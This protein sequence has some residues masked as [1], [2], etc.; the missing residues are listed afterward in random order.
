MVCRAFRSVWGLAGTVILAGCSDPEPVKPIPPAP[1]AWHVVLDETTLDRAVLSVWGSSP[2]N[3]FAVGGALGNGQESLVLHYDGKAWKELHPGGTETYWWVGGSG[4]ND[5]WMVG[6]N[7]RATHWDGSVFQEHA[8]GVMATLWG[9]WAASP[10]DVWFVGGTP[11]G[12]PAKPNDIVLH[13]DG[14]GF[15]NVTLP[16]ALGRSF[17]KVWGTNSDDLYVVGEA[18]TRAIASAVGFVAHVL[19]S[20]VGI[21]I[22]RALPVTHLRIDCTRYGSSANSPRARYVF[23]QSLFTKHNTN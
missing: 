14:Q 13:W 2:T 15:T 3:V 8:S 1:P 5:V 4:P 19:G 22:N 9:V 17:Y 12:G 10:T 20:K 18:A 21:V 16:K 7:G 11:E 23:R 6:E